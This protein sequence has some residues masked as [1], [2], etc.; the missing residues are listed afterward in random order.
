[1]K[2]PNKILY[3]PIYFCFFEIFFF[4]STIFVFNISFKLTKNKNCLKLS[5]LN[6][7]F[8]S[9]L[10]QSIHFPHNKQNFN[11]MFKNLNRL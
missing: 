2:F 3:F 5:L 8:K 1:M 9:M 6:F 10:K 7:I 11:F 4:F